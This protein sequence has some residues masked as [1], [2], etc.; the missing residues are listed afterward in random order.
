MP[1]ALTERDTPEAPRIAGR[2]LWQISWLRLRR[3]R[4]AMTGGVIVL[5][6]FVMA[7]AAPL[8][9]RLEGQD[10]Y[11][12]HIG[13]LNG[14]AGGA[15]NGA[16][17]GISGTHWFGV[18]PTTGRDLFA[19]VVYGAR[20]SF[21]I[22]IAATFLAVGLGTATGLVAAYFGGWVDT[23]LG[24]FMDVMF[25]FPALIFMISLG[26]LAPP[27]F[28]R[29]L[30]LILVIGFF[31]FPYFGR[32]IRGQTLSLIRREFVDA[33]RSLGA[34]AGHIIVKQLLPNLLAPIIVFATLT[35]PGMIG[36]EAS[37]SFLGVGIPPPTPDWGRAIN[38]AVDWFQTDLMYLLFPGGALFLA[39]LAFN[40][41]GDGL[42]DAFDPRSG[43]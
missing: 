35:I 13:L 37:L 40:L 8:L 15:P 3:D 41:F 12:Y 31:G 10:P 34:G 7:I 38:D 9:A 32:V 11:T 17:G 18:E 26:I 16:L 28:P 36:A 27:S 4:V 43:R 1:E 39:V 20:T 29:P 14:D 21:L 30:L 19:V 23:V 5:L 33:A 42:R 24:R 25:G 22:G 2:S 6:Y